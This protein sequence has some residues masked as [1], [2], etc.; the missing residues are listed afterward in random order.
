MTEHSDLTREGG[1]FNPLAL[2]L[3]I[4]KVADQ[5]H[6]FHIAPI[7]ELFSVH[8]IAQPLSLMTDQ[9]GCGIIIL[10][11][12]F[13]LLVIKVALIATRA[14]MKGEIAEFTPIIKNVG[15]VRH[16]EPGCFAQLI[17]Q[18][19]DPSHMAHDEVPPRPRLFFCAVRFNHV[20]NVIRP[21]PTLVDDLPPNHPRFP[22]TGIG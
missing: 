11:Q 18:R 16:F 4:V 19:I 22:P 13:R 15:M 12:Q 9:M 7:A 10:G 5:V 14:L 2:P 17:G 21:R 8:Q 3:A 6:H 1:V 20:V